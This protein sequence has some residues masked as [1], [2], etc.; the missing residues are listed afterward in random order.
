[1]VVDPSLRICPHVIRSVIVNFIFIVVNN[2]LSVSGVEH[3]DSEM[4]VYFL[5]RFLSIVAY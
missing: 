5:F 1:M 4:Y 2:D 3:S